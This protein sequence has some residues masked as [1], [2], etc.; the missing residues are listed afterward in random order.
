MPTSN[1]KGRQILAPGE[2][3]KQTLASSSGGPN[4]SYFERKQREKE[5]EEPNRKYF[6]SFCINKTLRNLIT[7]KDCSHGQLLAF[8]TKKKT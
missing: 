8:Q 3:C 6:I 1:G 2:K 7:R 5:K 4:S